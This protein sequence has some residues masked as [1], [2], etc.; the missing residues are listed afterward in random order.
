VDDTRIAVASALAE[1]LLRDAEAQTS[2]S[3][4]RRAHR[5]GR[6]LADPA[7]RELLFSLT[8]EV[9]RTPDPARAVDRLHRLLRAGT[10]SSL[11][12]VDRSGLQLAAR[13]GRALPRLV[14]R[15][16]EQRVRAET[17]GVILSAAD[18]A[19]ARHVARRAHAGLDLNVNLLGEAILGDDEADAR[20]D[21][22]CRRLRRADVG[23]VSV[24][25]SALCA[26]LDVLAFDHSVDRICDRL[27]RL[28][29]RR[30]SCTSTWR[31]TAI[32]I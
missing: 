16:V 22:V 19:F 24:K 26:N 18:P 32:S 3:E 20:L 27:R 25:I 2:R 6:L 8:D 7:G 28:Y 14:T 5:L 29:R 11:G 12:F 1:E 10:P 31:S 23:C 4:R 13:T 17:R 21:A 9:M 15:V 30:S